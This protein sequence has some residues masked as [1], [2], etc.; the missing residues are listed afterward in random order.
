MKSAIHKLSAIAVA[1]VFA[2]TTGVRA[3]T[4]LA[5]LNAGGSFTSGDLTFSGFV[6][7]QSGTG[8]LPDLTSITY[9][10]G[11]P[12]VANA[13]S[14][15][16]LSGIPWDWHTANGSASPSNSYSLSINYIVTAGSGSLLN[17]S[18]IENLW[19]HTASSSGYTPPTN[20]TTTLYTSYGNLNFD[21]GNNPLIPTI[22]T[23]IGFDTWETGSFETLSAQSVLHVTTFIEESTSTN[24]WFNLNGGPTLAGLESGFS[25]IT[26]APEPTTLALAA[27]GGASLLLFRRRK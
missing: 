24:Y 6:I 10:A 2:S 11:S 25:E 15:F 18:G 3:Q 23:N 26:P 7:S 5:D 16:T 12:H 19:G 27:L 4:T 22:S 17:G 13:S 14:G 1:A 9:S 20:A 8:T 21:A